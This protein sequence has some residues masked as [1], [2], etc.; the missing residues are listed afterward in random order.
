MN[1]FYIDN[2]AMH[3]ETSIDYARVSFHL[4]HLLEG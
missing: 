1:F 4:Y 3:A 2:L